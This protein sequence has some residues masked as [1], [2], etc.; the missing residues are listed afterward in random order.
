MIGTTRERAETTLVVNSA[1]RL[2]WARDAVH[3]EDMAKQLQALQLLINIAPAETTE[4]LRALILRLKT[5]PAAAQ[6]LTH[7]MMGM[8]NARDYLLDRDLKY[9]FETS[10][11]ELEKICNDFGCSW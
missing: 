9:I 11:G 1:E 2:A 5:D 10:D 8:A 7:G 6:L 4:I 3:S